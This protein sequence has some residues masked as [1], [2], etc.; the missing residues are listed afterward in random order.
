MN[1]WPPHH[2]RESAHAEGM[3]DASIQRVLQTASLLERQNL[4]LLLTL[5]HLASVTDVEYSFLRSVVERRRDVPTYRIHRIQKRTPGYRTICIPHPNLKRTQQWL[6]Q[7]VL[8]G[9]DAHPRAFAYHPG[10]SVIA[11]AA[12]HCR[13][14]WLVRLDVRKFFESIS[15]RDVFRVFALAGYPPL[16][17]FELARI[18]TRVYARDALIYRLD[19]PWARDT[20]TDTAIPS[21]NDHRI[22]HV[23]QGAPTSAMLSNLVCR[24]LDDRLSRRLAAWGWVYSRYSDDVYISSH[25]TGRSHNELARVI[26]TVQSELQRCRFVMNAHKTAVSGPGDRKLVLGLVV[27]GPRPVLSRRFKDG[28]RMHLHYIRRLGWVAHAERRRFHSTLSLNR[29]LQGLARWAGQV[30]PD[31]GAWLTLQLQELG[32]SL[33]ETASS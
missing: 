4:P 19:S 25:R 28:M 29:H 32:A 10:R 12:L 2:Y 5:N 27:N 9:L 26:S 31:Y 18:C 7:F 16:L 24:G 22:G 21:Y 13:S 20:D 15:E 23:P 1:P 6:S 17:S 14:S 33:G 8:S 3:D 11:C 30:E